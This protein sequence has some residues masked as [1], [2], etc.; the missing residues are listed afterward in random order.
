MKT[1]SIFT[2]RLPMPLVDSPGMREA[3][4]EEARELASYAGVDLTAEMK[5]EELGTGAVVYRYAV[6]RQEVWQ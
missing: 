3:L 6:W 5:I 2:V 4:A 1:L